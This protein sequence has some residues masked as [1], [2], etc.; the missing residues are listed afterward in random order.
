M[1]ERAGPLNEILARRHLPALDGLRA[2]SVFIVIGYHFGFSRIPG[3]LGV[4]TF[5]VLSG[6]LITWLLMKE[7]SEFGRVSLGGFYARRTLRIFPAYYAFLLFSFTQECVRG[8][9]WSHGLL[10]SGISYTVNYYNAFQG[11]PGTAIAHA[12]SLGLEEQ[13]YLIWP[14]IFIALSRM[15]TGGM[16]GALVGMIG[17]VVAWRSFLV[18]GVGASSAY[19][20]NALDTRLDTLLIGCLLAVCAERRWFDW[21]AR[22]VG[23]SMLLPIVTLCLLVLSRTWGSPRYHYSLGFTIDAFLIAVFI[24]Q[25]VQLYRTGLWSWLEH[26][27][28]RYLG[29]ISYPLYLYHQF[30]LGVGRRLTLLPLG[31]KLIAGVA[32]TI[33]LASGS[34]Y[35]IERPFLAIKRRFQPRGVVER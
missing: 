26:P 23:Q 14:G 21:V 5:F 3:D 15:Q 35:L 29:R 16:T 34:Y 6:F 20:Y 4:N 19:L 22:A 31:G 18:F 24:T 13:F 11:H 7:R 12:W 1:A 8:Y 33:L 9:C 28:A 17:T 32:M 27:V 2:V 10:L 25:T 30:G